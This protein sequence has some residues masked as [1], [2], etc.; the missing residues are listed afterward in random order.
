MAGQRSLT[1]KIIGDS[2][3]LEKAFQKSSTAGKKYQQDISL[4]AKA[5]E[6]ISKSAAIAATSLVGGA[7]LVSAIHESIDAAIRAQEVQK[8]TQTQL[9]ALGISYQDHADQINKVIQK[10][11]QLS[12]FDDEDL[13]SSFTALVRVTKD[14]N[15]ALDLNALAADVAR[16]KNI[17]LDTAT[18]IV[19]KA[20]L[21]QLGALKRMGIEIPP[22]TA[23]VDALKASHEKATAAQL[24]AAK[25]ADATA[26]RQQALAQ[27]QKQFSGQ[28]EA[29][30]NT[31]AGAQ[32]RLKVAT[33]NLRES[34]GTALLPTVTKIANAVSGWVGNAD[35]LQK[36]QDGVNKVTTTAGQVI[37][38][39]WP[40][41]KTTA[42]WADELAQK[43]GGWDKV[44]EIVLSGVLAKKMAGLA[45]SIG[46]GNGL[47]GSLYR[48]TSGITGTGGLLTALRLIPSSIA[49][50][51]V[52]S[53]V[54]P[55]NIKALGQDTLDAAGIGFMGHL[56]VVGSAVEAATGLGRKAGEHL[57]IKSI[58]TGGFTSGTPEHDA[59]MAGLQGNAPPND[60]LSSASLTSA[61]Y[62]GRRYGGTVKPANV[63]SGS[64]DIAGVAAVNY[65]ASGNAS[66]DVSTAKTGAGGGGGG[67]KLSASDKAAAAQKIIDARVAKL[68]DLAIRLFPVSQVGPLSGFDASSIAADKARTEQQK[69]AAAKALADRVAA[70][71]QAVDGQR[72][73]FAASF[74]KLGDAAQKAIEQKYAGMQKALA[75]S[76]KSQLAAIE[77]ARAEL[78]PAEKQLQDLQEAHDA[79][80]L[81]DNL[82]A[83]Q[84][85][86][87]QKQIADAQ[88]AIQIAALQKQAA[89]ERA[90][91]N[92]DASAKAQAAQDAYDQQQQIYADQLAADKAAYASKL[93]SL[94]TYL[95]T[96][97]ASVDDANKIM[98]ESL[99]E[100]ASALDSQMNDVIATMNALQSAAGVPTNA[101]AALA[102]AFPKFHPQAEGGDYM[103]TGPTLFLAGEAGAER[104]TFS[105]MGGKNYHGGGSGGTTIQVNAGA[106]IS[107][108]D[109]SEIVRRQLILMGRSSAATSVVNRTKTGL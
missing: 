61:Y 27:L 39:L 96:R 74:T 4:V 67:K 78:T 101:A 1:V 21:G 83:A 40:K 38:D 52:V 6:G 24:A 106:V 48:A 17:D 13:Q 46:G 88:Y 26:T 9:E 70:M 29:Y 97:N 19:T 14:V 93:D 79:Q 33:E 2:S 53:A 107:E 43:V 49:V 66:V 41:V 94:Q 68:D 7:G 100:F 51:V 15:K 86:G 91:R 32:D 56:P 47:A 84:A 90:A 22:V 87:D 12:A 11:S 81:Q 92:E 82:A 63:A 60:M 55:K 42:H 80:A 62:K 95:S 103:V 35:N 37:D 34:I 25:A 20:S 36:V 85:S 98:A 102:V 50:A 8:R 73:R 76:L 109:L 28:A 69:Q 104:A 65:A 3:S 18:Q 16:G 59:Y 99:G 71:A 75:D 105:R 44:F 77:K 31:A 72:T 54:V 57:G 89:A 5:H 23:A 45:G 64:H 108:R 58:D 30:G 10:Q